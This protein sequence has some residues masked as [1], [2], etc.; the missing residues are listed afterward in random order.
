MTLKISLL[1][2]GVYL[3]CGC[4]FAIPFVWRGVGR[5]DPA[6]LHGSPGFRWIILPGTILLWPLLARRWYQ[7]AGSPPEE[8]TAHRRASRP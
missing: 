1:A 8:N 4:L 3:L 5:I 6:A 2:L 7:G